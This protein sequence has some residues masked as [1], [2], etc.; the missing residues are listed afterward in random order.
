MTNPAELEAALADPAVQELK[1]LQVVEMMFDPLDLPWRLKMGLE[2]RG[3]EG[4]LRDEG[5]R[6]M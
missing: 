2:V 6:S 3:L 5:F 1:E 4:Y